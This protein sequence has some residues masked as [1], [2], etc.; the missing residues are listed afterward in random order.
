MVCA[1]RSVVTN[2]TEPYA[3]KVEPNMYCCNVQQVNLQLFCMLYVECGSL[4]RA[5]YF[6]YFLIFIRNISTTAEKQCFIMTATTV[7]YG[8][9][10]S[11]TFREIQ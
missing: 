8:S 10:L 4:M 3:Q 2:V 9:I 11:L 7:L 5:C 6:T 1:I